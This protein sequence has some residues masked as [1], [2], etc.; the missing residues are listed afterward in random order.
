MWTINFPSE[1]KLKI[2]VKKSTLFSVLFFSNHA[3]LGLLGGLVWN[4]FLYGV[5]SGFI[6]NKKLPRYNFFLTGSHVKCVAIGNLRAAKRLL[7]ITHNHISLLVENGRN[8]NNVVAS[9]PH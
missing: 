5:P 3:T 1:F 9:P 6:A 2:G 8:I 7:V 4:F